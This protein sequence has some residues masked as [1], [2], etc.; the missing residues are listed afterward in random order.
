MNFHDSKWLN[1]SKNPLDT[2]NQVI[3]NYSKS[4]ELILNWF[5]TILQSVEG[6]HNELILPRLQ[7]KI[8]QSQRRFQAFAVFQ[9]AWN[10]VFDHNSSGIFENRK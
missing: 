2:S 9:T 3:K 6:K 10:F 1:T 8:A 5:L 7:K 4:S